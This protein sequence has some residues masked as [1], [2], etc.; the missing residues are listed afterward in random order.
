M[1]FIDGDQKAP[2]SIDTTTRC[3][4]ARYSFPWLFL[5]TLDPYFIM[6]NVKQGGIKYH[7]LS[8]WYDSTWDWNEKERDRKDEV[9][10]IFRTICGKLIW[11]SVRETKFFEF[12]PFS[13]LFSFYRKVSKFIKFWVFFK[14]LFCRILGW[15][16]FLPNFLGRTSVVD[17]HLFLFLAKLHSRSEW[18]NQSASLFFVLSVRSPNS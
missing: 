17:L 9:L 8:R 1:N 10:Q 7:F 11:E 5:F 6:L 3:R 13:F 4:G 18:R 14:V 2:F 16:F 12:E 15:S